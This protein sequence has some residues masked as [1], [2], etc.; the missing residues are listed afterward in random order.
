MSLVGVHGSR[1][2]VGEVRKGMEGDGRRL[3]P[4]CWCSLHGIPTGG[5]HLVAANWAEARMQAAFGDTEACTDLLAYWASYT[6]D[7]SFL[8]HPRV[9]LLQ[10]AFDSLDQA[11]VRNGPSLSNPT[12][13]AI[14]IFAFP[15]HLLM[16]TNPSALSLRTP[17]PT[18]SP[19]LTALCMSP[20]DARCHLDSSCCPYSLGRGENPHSLV[21]KASTPLTEV[22][23]V[24]SLCWCNEWLRLML[25]SDK[26]L[27]TMGLK[28]QGLLSGCQ[29]RTRPQLSELG[30]PHLD[31]KCQRAC[32]LMKP[33]L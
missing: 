12:D 4:A 31:I 18:L 14:L 9:S 33:E 30:Y 10:S 29:E 32:F 6:G 20:L 23:V 24:I 26:L 17:S 28:V 2:L 3:E 11:K 5:S 27:G 21:M 8:Y 7:F 15:L 16:K 19:T 22:A 13:F 25:T 1:Q